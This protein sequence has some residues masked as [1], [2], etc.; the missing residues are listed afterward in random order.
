MST[1]AMS[2]SGPPAVSSSTTLEPPI[3]L[4]DTVLTQW[5]VP[6]KSGVATSDA[7]M[8]WE[9][10]LKASGEGG[11]RTPGRVAPTPVFKTGAI[12]R[13]ATSPYSVL[14]AG[15]YF[16]SAEF[17]SAFS[18]VQRRCRVLESLGHCGIKFL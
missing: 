13:S 7:V 16:G 14:R 8:R 18:D 5:T 4:I 11:I 17:P 12:D 1:S 10:A 15:S 6:I 2:N 3:T 9:R